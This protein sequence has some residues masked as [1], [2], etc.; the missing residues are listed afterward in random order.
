MVRLQASIDGRISRS[1]VKFRK[2][3]FFFSPERH[4]LSE[5]YYIKAMH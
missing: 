2:V 3:V 4:K 5:K 1:V